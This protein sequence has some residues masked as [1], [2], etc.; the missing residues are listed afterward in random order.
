MKA[1]QQAH[2]AMS[3]ISCL[4]GRCEGH[5]FINSV[6][7][8][9]ASAPFQLQRCSSDDEPG[10]APGKARK[11]LCRCDAGHWH[12]QPLAAQVTIM[13]QRILLHDRSIRPAAALHCAALCK[14]RSHHASR[15]PGKPLGNDSSARMTLK[16]RMIEQHPR[17]CTPWQPPQHGS[18]SFTRQKAEAELDLSAP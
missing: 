1:E 15:A 18:N 12:H 11:V 16:G 7:A 5:P 8:I 4:L 17:N 6:Q 10:P 2:A 3:R 9:D 14:Q 13:Q